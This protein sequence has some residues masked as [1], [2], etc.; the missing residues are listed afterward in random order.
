MAS[1]RS[2]ARS[3][4]CVK[5]GALVSKSGPPRDNNAQ[6]LNGLVGLRKIWVYYFYLTC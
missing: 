2:S 6:L 4:T 1:A 3:I 5:A